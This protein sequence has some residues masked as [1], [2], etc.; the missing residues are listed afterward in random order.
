[1]QKS[2]RT[3]K[4]LSS[5]QQIGKFVFKYFL[6]KHNTGLEFSMYTSRQTRELSIPV[7]WVSMVHVINP[8]VIIISTLC[9]S[10]TLFQVLKNRP[11]KTDVRFSDHA[12]GRTNLTCYFLMHEILATL[13]Y[14][15]T[16]V[17]KFLLQ[18]RIL[19]FS[20]HF[21]Y[22]LSIFFNI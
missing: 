11:M 1:M 4:F 22:R 3:L 14:N 17:L 5:A 19:L 8:L 12:E 16:S 7:R 15:I 10:V 21:Q 18:S 6:P 9:L 2:V 13:N 20:S